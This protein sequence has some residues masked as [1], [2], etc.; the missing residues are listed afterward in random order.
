MN[1]LKQIF[2]VS[3]GVV[4]K[5]NGYVAYMHC[6][7]LSGTRQRSRIFEAI[8]FDGESR[9]HQLKNAIMEIL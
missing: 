2:A 7:L 1:P 4:W 8:N 5:N 3:Y 6:T 9:S